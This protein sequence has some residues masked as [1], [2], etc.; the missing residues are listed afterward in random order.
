MSE[1]PL[2][3]MVAG[4]KTGPYPPEKLRP[5]MKDGRISPLD[6]FSYD[7]SDW[8]PAT[9]FPELL[10]PPAPATIVGRPAKNPLAE[11]FTLDDGEELSDPL[12]PATVGEAGLDDAATEK[13]LAMIRGLIWV[14]VGVVV[15]LV[16]L[17][18]VT[19]LMHV[20][21]EPSPEASPAAE[22][23]AAPASRL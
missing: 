8:R 6:R 3:R 17:M 4:R 12:R 11:G 16:L 18:V 2:W 7:G 21:S 13:L 20:A 19:S 9:E 1:A 23:K 14:G 10:R 5:L 22:T 15:I